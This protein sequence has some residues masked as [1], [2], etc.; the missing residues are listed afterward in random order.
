MSVIFASSTCDLNLKTLKKVD[1]EV[2]NLP[3][4]SNG[5]KCLYNAD[6]FDFDQYYANGNVEVD[7]DKYKKLLESKFDEAL[8]TGQDVLFMTSNAKYDA[9]YKFVNA[10]I[11]QVSPNYPQQK[12]EM[13]NCGNYSL[14]YGLI[15]YEAGILN[16]RG[17]NISEVINF[18]NTIKQGIKTYI[19]PSSNETIKNKL[20]LVGSTIGV[21]PVL[22]VV[23]GELKVVDNV[24]GK[25]KIIS[26]LSD[27]AKANSYDLPFAIMFGK[28]TDEALMLEQDIMLDENDRVLFKSALNPLML[29]SFGDKTIAISYYKKS[30]K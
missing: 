22:E 30:K 18:I 26:F 7:Q 21:R 27:K 23:D 6:K 17:A 19:I 14:G 16:M 11:K 20:T 13:V 2:I 25:K 8:K 9:S 4:I 29:Q 10:I 24:R 5:K 15:V 28:N 3:L 1:V 12:I